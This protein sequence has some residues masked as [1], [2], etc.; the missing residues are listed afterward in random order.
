MGSR[1]DGT[2]TAASALPMYD[3]NDSSMPR[4]MTLA[5]ETAEP[6][7]NKGINLTSTVVADVGLTECCTQTETKSYPGY[8]I[9]S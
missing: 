5:F 7:S 1:I 6:M 4:K 3:G 8:I 2:L 9:H